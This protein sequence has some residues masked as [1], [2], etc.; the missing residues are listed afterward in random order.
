MNRYIKILNVSLIILL[1]ACNTVD[2]EELIP[3]TEILPTFDSTPSPDESTAFVMPTIIYKDVP[4]L[5]TDGGYIQAI[6]FDDEIK[7]IHVKIFGETFQS[8]F[9]YSFIEDRIVISIVR[10]NYTQ[11]YYIDPESMYIG[12]IERESYLLLEDKLYEIVG[13]SDLMHEEDD[14]KYEAVKKLMNIFIDEVVD[15]I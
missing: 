7:Y 12:S 13:A 14:E 11:P 10:E 6:L 9:H 3:A 4:D 2:F 8:S 1:T 5:S 15:K